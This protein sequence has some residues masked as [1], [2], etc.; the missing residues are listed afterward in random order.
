MAFTEGLCPN[1]QQKLINIHRD[2]APALQRTPVGYIDA[3]LS[4]ENTSGFEK[5]QT[6][7]G[8][9]KRR[10]VTITYFQRGI[11]TDTT[12][13]PSLFCTADI[14]PAPFEVEIEAENWLSLKALVFN[15]EEMRKICD[16][17]DM[18]IANIMDA[19]LDALAVQLDVEALTLQAANFGNF[20]DGTNTVHTIYPLD[21]NLNAQPVAEALMLREYQDIN[22][23]GT[24]LVVAAGNMDI[25]GRLV[26]IG[27]CNTGGVDVSKGSAYNYYY[28]RNVGAAFGDNNDF[29]VLQPGAVQLVTWNRFVGPYA[30]KSMEW[31]KSTLTDPKTGITYDMIVHYEPCAGDAA[32]GRYIINLGLYYNVYFMPADAY[33]AGDELFGV[34][35]TLYFNA[36]CGDYTC[37]D[38]PA[39]SLI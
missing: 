35:G 24:P 16:P 22:G 33:Q 34:N 2:G 12:S 17:D 23:K 8:S 14:E 27:C 30:K 28:D 1:I 4:P 29:A 20:I 26:N 36:S 32:E 10:I 39:G 25:Y 13:D 18:W 3:I 19:Y 6:N 31:E 38:L 15:E 11:P 5:I 7:D 37:S 9:G 21:D